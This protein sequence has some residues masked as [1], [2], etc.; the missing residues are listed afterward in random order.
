MLLTEW[1][2]KDALEVER[3][4]AEGKRYVSARSKAKAWFVQSPLAK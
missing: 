2:L 1:N 3:E 4:E